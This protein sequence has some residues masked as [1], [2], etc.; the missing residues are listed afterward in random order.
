MNK[1]IEQKEPVYGNIHS[2][3]TF[4]AVDGPGLR[5]V[6]FMEG[7][8]LR[9]AYCC[10]R[11]MLDMEG[12]KKYTPEQL[13]KEVLKYKPYFG[14]NGGVTLSGGDP[15]FQPAF[16]HEFITLCKREN[17]HVALD[18][19]LFVRTEVL[20]DL[21]PMVDLFMVSL[22]HFDDTVHK[23]MTLVSN[24]PILENIRHLNSYIKKSKEKAPKLRFRYVV[25]PGYTDTESNLKSL[26]AFL[27]DMEFELIE[28]LPY[29]EYGKFKWKELGLEYRLEGMRLPSVA[30][31]E[32]IKARLEN[33][34]YNVLL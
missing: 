4:G 10:N 20:D 30:S 26:I 2:F 9:C 13:I 22:K 27:K 1:N 6:I 29:H 11:D 33:E 23:E 3:E 31:V 25:L 14:A 21:M 7:C 8:P 18:T 19:S 17:I 12:Y 32:K 5:M 28:L 15:V 16:I 24:D 34:G